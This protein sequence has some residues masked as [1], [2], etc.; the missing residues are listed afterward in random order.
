MKRFLIP[1]KLQLKEKLLTV[2]MDMIL[3]G[4]GQNLG[5]I[6]QKMLTVGKKFELEDSDGKVVASARKKIL[7]L[8]KQ[9]EIYDSKDS[10]LG[11]IEHEIIKSATSPY[12][13]YV[14]KDENGN[15]LAQSREMQIIRT[16]VSIHDNNG[17]VA[18]MT[19]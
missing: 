8:T 18:D 13:K 16:A 2:G 4:S 5:I 15:P 14:I 10:L 11:T 12:D 19:K 1:K 7:A 9:F 6:K 17:K 3:L